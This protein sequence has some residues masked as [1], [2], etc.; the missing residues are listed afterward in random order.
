M[1]EWTVG[2]RNDSG[3][4]AASFKAYAI[5]LTVEPVARLDTASLK[6]RR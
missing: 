2:M 6:K 1:T 4:T 5:C 3:P